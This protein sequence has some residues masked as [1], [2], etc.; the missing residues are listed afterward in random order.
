MLGSAI[1]A[2]A[3]ANMILTTLGTSAAM[4]SVD[5]APNFAL[6]APVR[7]GYT[8]AVTSNGEVGTL[9][10]IKCP[11]MLSGGTPRSGAEEPGPRIVTSTRAVYA[12]VAPSRHAHANV[13]LTERWQLM[14]AI[15]A[16]N[17]ISLF[18]LTAA[19]LFALIVRIWP[20]GG[21]VWRRES[22][23]S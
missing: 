19:F 13:Y 9:A 7:P 14:G 18:G 20:V 5:P 6:T 8:T 15:E 3:A 17:G 4:T 10:L 1:T 2:T 21:M 16:L 23:R 22:T 11:R 12:P